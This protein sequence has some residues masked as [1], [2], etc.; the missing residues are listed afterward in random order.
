[1]DFTRR[2]EESF[3][4]LIKPNAK[5]LREAIE[6]LDVT[7]EDLHPYITDFGPYPYGRKMIYKSDDVEMLVM[8]W[9]NHMDCAPHDHG[10]SM[11]WV[12]VLEGES[13]HILYDLDEDGV[14]VEKVTRLEAT[15]THVYAGEK[16]IHAMGNHSDGSLVTVHVY[17]PPITGMKVYDLEKCAVCIVSDDCG[18]W[19]PEH[20]RQILQ[21][22]KLRNA[23]ELAVGEKA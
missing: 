7:M 11:G 21:E 10:S 16:M 5:E 3:G 15:G 8:N 12:S 9:S 22:I 6:R 19:W 23:S 20:D 4:H 18:A 13:T 1:M 17:S 2:M 14:P